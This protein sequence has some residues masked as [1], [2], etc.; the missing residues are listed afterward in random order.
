LSATGTTA[1]VAT[2][3]DDVLMTQVKTG[4]VEAFEEL[5]DRYCDRAY[6]V[7]WCACHDRSRSE[8]AVQEAF[9]SIWKSRT[10]YQPQRGAVA[11]WLLTTVRYRAIDAVRR[12]RKHSERRAPAQAIDLHAAPENIADHVASRDEAHRL[13]E[14]LT[15]LPD[16]QREVITL[17]FYGGL[18]HTEIAGALQ[19]PAG[20]VKGRMR[21]GMRKL[22][23][24]L[25]QAAA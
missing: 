19:L 1:E 15:Q 6:R 16:T 7:A 13:R 8:D 25:E 3:D 14:L 23:Q 24:A 18:S 9:L 12:D 20:T 10:D 4:S 22:R 17:A 21:L 11:A 2:Y 5:Y